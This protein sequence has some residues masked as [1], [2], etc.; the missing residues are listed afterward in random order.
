MEQVNF[1]IEVFD[2]GSGTSLLGPLPLHQIFA[3]LA[4]NR[5]GVEDDGDPV[6]LF[7]KVNHRWLITQFEVTNPAYFC[8]A[9]STSNDATSTWNLYAFFTTDFND[10]PKWG[11]W[12]T[13]YF[14]T[15]NHFNNSGSAYLDARLHA[16]NDVKMRAGD[17]SAEHI[18]A[19][20]SSSDYSILPAD[21]D[22]VLPPPV[23]Q[24]EFFIG[25]YDVDSS[26]NHLYLYSMAPNFAAGTAVVTGSE[27]DEP[28]YCTHLRSVLRQQ[29]FL[30]SG[31]GRFY[32]GCTW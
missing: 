9:V 16:F 7:D 20:L 23:G 28:D 21:V 27:S 15:D 6:V 1:D 19:T 3:N 5:C 24:P 31:A 18:T 14:A 2:K 32:P 17:P 26:N 10:Y 25:S 30:R 29:P 13:G 11:M 4:P 12:P 22:S 8:A